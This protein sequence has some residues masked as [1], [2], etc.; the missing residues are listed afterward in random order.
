[1]KILLYEYITGGG[2]ANQTIPN[3]LLSEGFAML[4]GLSADFKT[5]G[6]NITVLLDLRLKPIKD[7]LEAN[8][9]VYVSSDVMQLLPSL[10]PAVDA[11][12]VVAPE[13]ENILSLIVNF[14]EKQNVISLNCSSK[15]IEQAS[16]KAKLSKRINKLG[17]KTPQTFLFKTENTN[18][19]IQTLKGKIEFP[20]IVKPVNGA[21]C[22][23]LVLIN[24]ENQLIEVIHEIKS[25]HTHVLIQKL[26]EGIPVS[27]SLFSNGY[28]AS[29]ISL[30]KQEINLS[31]SINSSSSCYNGGLV[32]FEDQR[33][34]D[35]YSIAKQVVES[36]KGLK[37]YVG[38]DLILA[39]D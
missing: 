39:K 16:D 35:A 32:P 20:V 17:L 19:I 8:E 2:L 24:Q 29:P 23:D 36:Y 30:N 28:L 18:K 4:R 1:M 31:S 22:T 26:I 3:S 15:A 27:V 7:F 38:V 5:A 11:V 34:Q 33:K 9:I 13:S 12:F 25:K 10:L 37:G 14:V 21:G 6:H